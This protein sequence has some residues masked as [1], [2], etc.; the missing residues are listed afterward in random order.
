MITNE[1]YNNLNNIGISKLF[2]LSEN[3]HFFNAR[4]IFSLAY[5]LTS[6][7]FILKKIFFNIILTGYIPSILARI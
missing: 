2:A 4:L 5:S 7:L 6:K 1:K 3:G